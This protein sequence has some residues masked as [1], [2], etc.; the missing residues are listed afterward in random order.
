MSNVLDRRQIWA[1]NKL[2]KNDEEAIMCD[3]QF[4][5]F[6][7]VFENTISEKMDITVNLLVQS[8]GK[9]LSVIF[10]ISKKIAKKIS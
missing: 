6:F 4:V 7:H 9:L 1:I 2:R 10:K 5:C 3:F 8:P